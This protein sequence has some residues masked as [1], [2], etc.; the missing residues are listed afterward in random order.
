MAIWLHELKLF[1]RQRMAVPL[2]ILTL[3]VASAAVVAGV[4]EVSRQHDVIER[5]QP[6][7]AEDEAAVA[8]F[9]IVSGDPGSAEIGRA[10]WRE[11][12]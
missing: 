12:V 5:I 3:A 6:Q 11:R 7:Q 1:L 8:S 4:A 9:V 2:L 10:S